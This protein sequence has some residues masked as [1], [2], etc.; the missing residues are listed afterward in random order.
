MSPAV[1][2]PA[3]RKMSC[4]EA[5]VAELLL[6]LLTATHSTAPF[7]YGIRIKTQKPLDFFSF[8]FLDRWW[9]WKYQQGKGHDKG[10]NGIAKKKVDTKGAFLGSEVESFLPSLPPSLSFQTIHHHSVRCAGLAYSPTFQNTLKVTF[11]NSIN[12]SIL[13]TLAFLLSGTK[14]PLLSLVHKTF[15]GVGSK[16]PLVQTLN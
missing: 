7:W 15:P 10:V 3:H 2:L 13:K 11:P 16:T 8:T 1:G 12:N 5:N 14:D 6:F 4:C 9:N